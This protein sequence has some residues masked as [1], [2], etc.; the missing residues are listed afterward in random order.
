M[1]QELNRKDGCAE[2]VRVQKQQ[3]SLK[4]RVS[5]SAKFPFNLVLVVC[6]DMRVL[7]GAKLFHVISVF[8]SLFP[9]LFSFIFAKYFPVKMVRDTHRI[10]L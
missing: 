1:H 8:I 5:K 2:T 9:E 4:A 10:L 3:S 7:H 6:A